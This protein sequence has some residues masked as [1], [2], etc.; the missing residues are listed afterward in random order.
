METINFTIPFGDTADPL[1]IA[2]EIAESLQFCDWM[3]RKSEDSAEDDGIAAVKFTIM[4]W[5]TE[6]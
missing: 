1:K 3:L 5:T 2:A 6:W 4:G